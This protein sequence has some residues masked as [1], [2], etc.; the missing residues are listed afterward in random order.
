M[1][2]GVGIFVNGEAN[3]NDLHDKFV[4]RN[5]SIAVLTLKLNFREMIFFQQFQF[6]IQIAF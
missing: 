4:K 3:E 6:V 2:S 1:K 5:D